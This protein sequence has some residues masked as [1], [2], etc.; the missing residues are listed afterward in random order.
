MGRSRQRAQAG[1][2]DQ[3]GSVRLDKWLW[4]A[5]FFKTRALATEA[6]Q[7]GKVH[8]NG[9]RVKPARAVQPGDELC[10][11][12]G[13][14]E[15]TVTVTGLG[16]RRVSARVASTWYEESEASRAQREERIRQR[17]LLA[18]AMPRMPGRP[19]KKDRR[20]IHRFKRRTG[21]E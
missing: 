6:V 15:Y 19:N 21:N 10:I 4:A 8:L 20:L 13:D 12:K 5:R 14:L 2:P 18:A 17:R 9:Q 1:A 7:G 3:P 11:H 16:E